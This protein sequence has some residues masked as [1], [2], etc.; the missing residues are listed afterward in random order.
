[1]ANIKTIEEA[2]S[3][4]QEYGAFLQESFDDYIDTKR[5]E[6][7]PIYNDNYFMA[8]C[9]TDR[10]LRE[11]KYHFRMLAGNDG[12]DFLN[13]L[14]SHFEMAMERIKNNNGFARIILVTKKIPSFLI[15][16]KKKFPDHF[17]YKRVTLKSDAQIEHTIICDGDMVREEEIHLLL[18]ENTLA[19]AIRATVYFDNPARGKI[20]ASEFDGIWSGLEESATQ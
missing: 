6:G 10:M 13:L 8:L 18:D 1:M 3:L 5:E 17:D 9:F 11:T 12:N 16:L 7:K 20:R 14:K 2:K 19:G 15:S 4:F